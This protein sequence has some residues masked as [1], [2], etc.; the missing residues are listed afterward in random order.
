MAAGKDEYHAPTRIH[1]RK[2]W[3]RCEDFSRTHATLTRYGGKIGYPPGHGWIGVEF[4]AF[5]T[6]THIKNLDDI[7]GLARRVMRAGAGSR[8]EMPTDRIV[9]V[10]SQQSSGTVEAE[11]F[12][13]LSE[14]HRTPPHQ[15]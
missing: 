1:Q 8:K 11:R 10:P 2:V 14:H 9:T 7:P 3:R 12:Q 13:L 4:D 5:H 15:E 6:T